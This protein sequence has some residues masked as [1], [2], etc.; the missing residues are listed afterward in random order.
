MKKI[1]VMICFF[2]LI[3]MALPFGASASSWK[4]VPNDTVEMT[5]TAP[6]IDGVI[7][8][9]EGWSA[10][11]KFNED[12]VGYFG[13]PNQMLTGNADLYFAYTDD[14]LYFAV[15]YT[16]VGSAYCV[17]FFD[18][19]GNN[20]HTVVYQDP[21]ASNY[22]AEEGGYPSVTPDGIPIEYYVIPGANATSAPDG[23]KPKTAYWIS[24]YDQFFTD[25]TIIYSETID[26][27]NY[28]NDSMW[29]GD[30]FALS[31]DPLGLFR[32]LELKKNNEKANETDSEVKNNPVLYSVAIFA[33]NNVKVARCASSNNAE[34]TDSVTAAG[35]ISGNKMVFE[36]CIPWSVI[37]E[38]ANTLAAELGLDHTFTVDEVSADGVT[39]YAGVT[40]FDRFYDEEAGYS[41][42][43]GRFIVAPLTT[44]TG[45]NGFES[46]GTNFGAMGLKLATVPATDDPV[47]SN[48]P[49]V[50]GSDSANPNDSQNEDPADSNNPDVPG[51]DPAN[52]NDSQNADP[53]DSNNPDVPGSD[54]ANPDD[55]QNEGP[56]DPNKPGDTTKAGDTTKPGDTAKPGPGS[57]TTK[58]GD[59]TRPGSVTT[60]AQGTGNK[61]DGKGSAQ[62]FD[63][64][65][66]VAVGLLATSGIGI[67]YSRKRK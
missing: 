37:V 53:A 15:D 4:I 24:F 8:S 60:K 31:I 2:M 46:S 26:S 57:V 49:D 62:T 32:E 33:G 48:N 5:K 29:D 56:A 30:E 7:N 9:G 16:E 23:V 65:I 45:T 64:G 25:N 51:S 55:S 67:V 44:S 3:A 18:E 43:C 63:A 21:N 66:A 40:Y 11:A 22:Y 17:K 41:D 27:G 42:T 13:L 52:P 47:D 54:P 19:E 34:I 14:G 6:S 20:T 35:S 36:V 59:T 58:P 1:A 28:A 61:T 12:T 10:P 50:P 38:D 39:H